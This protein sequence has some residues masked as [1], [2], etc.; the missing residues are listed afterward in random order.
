M[1]RYCCR[2]W[3][4]VKGHFRIV[5]REVRHEGGDCLQNGNVLASSVTFK[6]VPHLLRPHPRWRNGNACTTRVLR[7]FLR[8]AYT[9][10]SRFFGVELCLGAPGLLTS[11]DRHI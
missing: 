9:G 2:T 11:T 1:G 6:G 8:D 10:T 3:R 5:A 7:A 4:S